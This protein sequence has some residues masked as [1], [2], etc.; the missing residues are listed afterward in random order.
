MKAEI[1]LG[2]MIL[3]SGPPRSGT[4]FAIQS[5]NYHPDFIAA[6]DDHVYEC[7]GLYNIMALPTF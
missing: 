6:I 4:T 3:I 2:K 7:W 1:I 5:L